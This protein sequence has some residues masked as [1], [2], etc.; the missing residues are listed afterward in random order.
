MHMRKYCIRYGIELEKLNRG[1]TKFLIKKKNPKDKQ[2]IYVN[3][4]ASKGKN[5]NDQLAFGSIFLVIVYPNH[6][7]ISVQYSQKDCYQTG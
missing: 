1:K 6:S 2:D 7:E 5:P 3:R 4:L